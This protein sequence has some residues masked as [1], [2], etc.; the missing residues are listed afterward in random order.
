MACTC[1]RVYRYLLLAH[2]DGHAAAKA[3]TSMQP[4]LVELQQQLL[5]S[6]SAHVSSGSRAAGAGGVGPGSAYSGGPSQQLLLSS[7]A[8]V[9]LAR[10]HT[11]LESLDKAELPPPCW[12]EVFAHLLLTGALKAF[13]FGYHEVGGK[14]RTALSR[15]GTHTP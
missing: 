3:I 9:Q 4:L 15:K 2:E 11:C 8:A 12:H 7:P 13:V 6:A 10:W 1:L 5:Q 14:V